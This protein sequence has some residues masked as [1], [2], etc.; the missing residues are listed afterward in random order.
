MSLDYEQLWEKALKSTE[1]IRSR[2]QALM[3][4]SDTHVP[5]IFLAESSVNLG[6]TVVRKGEVVVRKPS[7]IVPPNNPSLKGFDLSEGQAFQENMFM[8]F[9]L[10]RG[11]SIPSYHYDNRTS[12][13]EVFDGKLSLAIE[14]YN[15]LLQREENTRTGLVVGAEESWQFSLL[16]FICAQVAKNVDQDIRKLLDEYHKRTNG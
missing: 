1:I 14:H 11:V 4:L 3:S 12:A 7:I 5:Y 2:V 13:M 9:L 10:V 15:N 8:N 6:D 16:I